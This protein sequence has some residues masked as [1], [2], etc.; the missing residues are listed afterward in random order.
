[1][2]AHKDLREPVSAKEELQ[3]LV[4]LLS[5]YECWHLMHAIQDITAGERFWEGDVGIFYNEYIKARYHNFIRN[6][7]SIIPVDLSIEEGIFAPIPIVKSYTDAGRIPLPAPE[8]L[9]ATLTETLL[10]RRSR[11][12]YTG[13][14]IS[15]VQLST[16]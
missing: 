11:R 10:Y 3:S 5:E 12:D 6:P 13:Q 4:G 8:P 2:S 16:L 14:A 9:R 15:L 7:S 1:M